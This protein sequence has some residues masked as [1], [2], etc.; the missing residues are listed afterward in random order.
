MKKILEIS[1]IMKRLIIHP[2]DPST[3][4]LSSIYR[5]LDDIT[6]ITSGITKQN[7]QKYIA[8]ADQIL[9]MGHGSPNGLFGVGQFHNED[10]YVIDETM[11]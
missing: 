10:P 9:M 1:R 11:G 4:F 8:E 3:T 7:L 2:Q 5:N 6:V